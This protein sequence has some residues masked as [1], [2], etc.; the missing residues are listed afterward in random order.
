M[1]QE[2]CAQE[3]ERIVS[4]LFK[5]LQPLAVQNFVIKPAQLALALQSLW[6]GGLTVNASL[7]LQPNKSWARRPV[8]HCSQAE[9]PSQGTG[10]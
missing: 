9:A 8:N 3:P 7:Q 5:L 2:V 6:A 10:L 1:M 4:K